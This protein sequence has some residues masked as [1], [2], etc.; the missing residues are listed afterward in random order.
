MEGSTRLR[1]HGSSTRRGNQART[2][3]EAWYRRSWGSLPGHMELERPSAASSTPTLQRLLEMWRLRGL[4]RRP[5]GEAG[6][7]WLTR[8]SSR[9]LLLCPRGRDRCREGQRENG[10]RGISHETESQPSSLGRTDSDERIG[11]EGGSREIDLASCYRTYLV[12]I[13]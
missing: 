1:R 3:I 4:R 2:P 13:S 6:G 7:R 9:C 10:R 8:N 5:R 12:P 11:N